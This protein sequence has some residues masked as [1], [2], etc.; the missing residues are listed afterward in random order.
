VLSLRDDGL[1]GPDAVAW[2]VIGHPGALVGGLRSL[3]LQAL[4]PHAMAGV[5]QHSDY[6]RRPLD[7]LHRTTYYVAATAFGDT[8]TA[9]AAVERVRRRHKPVKGIDPVTG[10]AYSA[11]DPDTQLWVHTTEWHSF[12]AAYRVFGGEL[13]PGEQDRYMAEGAIVGSLLGTPRERVPA[14]IA[15]ARAYFEQVR[16]MLCMSDDARRAIDF[17]ASPT[18]TRE[19]L[20]YLLPLRVYGSAAVALVPRHLR[21]LA[22]IDRPRALDAAA[23]AAARPLVVAAGLPGVRSLNGL[24]VG[25]ETHALIEA[26][27]AGTRRGGRRLALRPAA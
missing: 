22:G 7:R 25:R 20:P 1:L 13:T 9:H 19:T 5:A 8:E 27:L 6:Q 17:V 24:V 4:H 2:R 18:P 26:R 3:I 21:R 15:E 10:A 23:I 14:S 12:L 16:P 11:D